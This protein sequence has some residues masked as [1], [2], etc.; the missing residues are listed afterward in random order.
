MDT[1]E[2]LVGNVRS[3]LEERGWSEAEL[4]RQSGVSQK[5]VNNIVSNRDKSASTKIS[6]VE[7]IAKGFG[8]TTA[9]LLTEDVALASSNQHNLAEEVGEVIQCFLSATLEGRQ[10]IKRIARH[11]AK[12]QKPS[13]Q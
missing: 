7:S 12:F 5:T 2:I 3:L 13:N 9:Q 4:A 10:T 6:T 1:F 11:E 8:V